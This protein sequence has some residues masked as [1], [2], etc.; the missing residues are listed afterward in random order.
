MPKQ[1]YCD[2]DA[3]AHARGVKTRGHTLARLSDVAAARDPLEAAAL[4]RRRVGC[5]RHAG[6]P[7]EL[8]CARCE[9][10]ACALCAAEVHGGHDIETLPAAIG[11]LRAGLQAAIAGVPFDAAAAGASGAH[12]DAARGAIA[13]DHAAL[14]AR[15]LA[16]LEARQREIRA[17]LEWVDPALAYARR[18]LASDDSVVAVAYGGVRAGLAAAAAALA[19]TDLA[20]TAPGL[21][22]MLMGGDVEEA[23]EEE[24]EEGGGGGGG[25]G[26]EPLVRT[27]ARRGADARELLRVV[28]GEEAA[29][30]ERAGSSGDEAAAL[31]VEMEGADS[32]DDDD[33]SSETGASS[34]LSGDFEE[35]MM[36]VVDEHEARQDIRSRIRAG[37]EVSAFPAIAEYVREINEEMAQDEAD[38]DEDE[39]MGD[40][41]ADTAQTE[42]EIREELAEV[43]EARLA[44]AADEGCCVG[45]RGGGGGGGGGRGGGGGGS[46]SAADGAARR[47]SAHGVLLDSLRE[48]ITCSVCLD[49]FTDPCMLPC[50]HTFCRGCIAGDASKK[51]PMCRA[52]WAAPA[53]RLP[54]NF[55]VASLVTMHRDS[56]AAAA[57]GGGG[58]GGDDDDGGYPSDTEDLL[59]ELDDADAEAARADAA[60]HDAAASFFRLLGDAGLAP[61]E[62]AALEPHVR[63]VTEAQERDVD[64][65]VAADGDVPLGSSG[66]AAALAADAAAVAAATEALVAVRP[67]LKRKRDHEVDTNAV[68]DE[69][70]RT[71]LVINERAFSRLVREV[72]CKFRSDLIWTPEAVEA[73]QTAAEEYM[74]ELFGHA[75]LAAAQFGRRGTLEPGD[76]QA[77]MVLRGERS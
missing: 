8:F 4:L 48:H 17:R 51:C 49:I 27:F 32:D 9:E 40:E 74:V 14:A 21:V 71:G 76:L 47:D 16:A 30:E 36:E 64:A 55:S 42:S 5:P 43:L 31:E 28:A 18:V 56:R 59:V 45:V 53:D 65:D 54:V 73:V 2:E 41:L 52:A 75:A 57:A 38:V 77:V 11:R 68:R 3:R 46:S 72:G 26:L 34:R 63:A 23:E 50:Q 61:P 39:E 66:A 25:G 6:R 10:A 69:Q 22:D 7:I 29:A 70:R 58:G 13:A 1:D 44:A 15:R 12:L 20:P 35:A 24:E 33:A 60:V 62:V 19:D 67:N 37:A